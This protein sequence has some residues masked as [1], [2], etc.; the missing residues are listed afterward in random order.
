MGTHTSKL[1]TRSGCIR[2]RTFGVVGLVLSAFVSGPVWAA[3]ADAVFTMGNYPVEGHA[4]DAVAAREKAVADGQRAAFRSLLKRLVPV[5]S[6]ARLKRLATVKI[7]DMLDGVAVKSERNSSTD[8]LANL[9]FIF[10]P[11]A[12]RVLLQKEGLAYVDKQAPILTVIPIWKAPADATALP[13]Q[14]LDSVG[15]KAWTD[16]WRG[17]DLAHA[18]TPVKLDAPN[19]GIKPDVIAMLAKGEVVP[20]R[21]ALLDYKTDVIVFAIAEP[22]VAKK[23]LY[24]TLAG[25]DDVGDLGWRRSY[26]LDLSDVGYTIEVAAV[27]SLGVLEGRWKALQ[28]RGGRPVAARSVSEDGPLTSVVDS[29]SAGN[30]HFGVEFRG[31]G[32]WQTLSRR[33]AEMPGVEDIDVAGLSARGARVTLKYSGGMNRLAEAAAQ[34]GMTLRNG[35]NGWMLSAQ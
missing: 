25:R 5:T 16:A 17:L 31:M 3:S 9:D 20:L 26:R 28:T 29:D 13:A 32:E 14:L 7:G 19:A 24:V 12:V 27:V 1:I 8:Y 10:Q 6:Y 4:N 2:R 22:D 18:L 33:L 34:Q 21:Q 23:R 30:L 35:A 11:Q 15:A